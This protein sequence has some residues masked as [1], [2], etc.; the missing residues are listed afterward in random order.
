MEPEFAEILEDRLKMLRF[1]S[2]KLFSAYSC[3][4]TVIK[5]DFHIQCL[6]HN[7]SKLENLIFFMADFCEELPSR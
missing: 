7:I 2:V 6:R 4:H 5:F 3:K 1:V